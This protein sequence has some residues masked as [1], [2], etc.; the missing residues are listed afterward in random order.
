MDGWRLEEWAWY[1]AKKTHGESGDKIS[2]SHNP[3][4]VVVASTSALNRRKTAG[5][6]TSINPGQILLTR[7]FVRVK[8]HAAVFA[9]L[10]TLWVPIQTGRLP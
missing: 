6:R 3:I 7:T 9:I 4:S 8:F 2:G 1:G 5:G 10:F